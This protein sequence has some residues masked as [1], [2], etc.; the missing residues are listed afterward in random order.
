MLVHRFRHRRELDVAAGGWLGAAAAGGGR[1]VALA[2]GDSTLPVYRRLGA[3]PPGQVVLTLDELVP[4][5]A[6]AVLRF[7]FRL[8]AVLPPT[9]ARALRPFTPAAWGV[10][11]L[12]EMA[13]AVEA[14]LRGFGLAAV[15]CGLG[16][17]GHVAFNQPPDR[18]ESRCRIVEL[19]PANQARLGTVAPATDAFTLG[20]GTLR[21]ASRVGVVVAGGDKQEALRQLLA[22]P[23]SPEC[24]ATWL[25]DHPALEVFVLEA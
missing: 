19:T 8:A 24:P 5:P 21:E 10:G 1:F 22:G 17:D 12:A 9:W 23:P 14:E 3:L 16:P 15:L 11:D 2:V 6:R 7:S 18:G 20:L 13:P 4:A 25:R